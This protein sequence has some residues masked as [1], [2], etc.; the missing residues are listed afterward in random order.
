M[1]KKILITGNTGL[2]GRAVMSRFSAE[3]DLEPIPFSTAKNPRS[4]TNE[5]DC[6]GAAEDV[7]A[8]IN[9]ASKLPYAACKWEEMNAV[10]AIGAKNIREAGLN[11]GSK[12]FVQASTQAVYNLGKNPETGFSEES[13]LNPNSDYSRSKLESEKQLMTLPNSGLIIL[14]ICSIFGDRP[15]PQT[16]VDYM[17]QCVKHRRPIIVWG[18][19]ERLYDILSAWDIAEVFVKTLFGG[20][21]GVYNL[22]SGQAITVKDIAKSF[23]RVT[24]TDI[25]YTPERQEKPGYFLNISKLSNKI[26][27]NPTDLDTGFRRMMNYQLEVNKI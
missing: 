15:S 26:E 10:N 20:L 7:W 14:R 24:G 2:L 4:V 19:G 25:Q 13:P 1:K 5:R 9:L 12:I 22:G 11:A 21:K 18:K 17:A 3:P 23:H 6:I 16:I 8:I 27:F